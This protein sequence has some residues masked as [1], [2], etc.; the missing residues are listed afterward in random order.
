MGFCFYEGKPAEVLRRKEMKRLVVLLVVVSLLAISSCYRPSW[1]RANTTYAELKRDSEWCKSHVNIGSTRAE[2]IEQYEKCMRD[3]GY[4]LKDKRDPSG[5]GEPIRV[6]QKEGPP[7]VI[8]KRAKVYVAFGSS[9]GSVSPANRYFHK[10]DCKHLWRVS[11]EEMTA[12]EAIARGKSMCS[13]CF[14]D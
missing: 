8:D 12:G 9:P 10:K 2:T 14:R 1:H 3:K 11:T 5:S 7:I 6:E 13:V 4:E